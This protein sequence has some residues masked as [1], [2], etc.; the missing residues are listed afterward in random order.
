MTNPKVIVMANRSEAVDVSTGD[1]VV[2]AIDKI[3]LIADVGLVGL[4]TKEYGLSRNLN[5]TA[6]IEINRR[7][8][9]NQE[10]MAFDDTLYRISDT[11]KGSEDSKIKLNVTLAEEDADLLTS[12]NA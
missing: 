2:S 6:T 11:A 5:F 1:V 9:S 12:M 4:K 7:L 10:F 8:Y 3:K